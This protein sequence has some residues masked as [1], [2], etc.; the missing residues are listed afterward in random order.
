MEGAVLDGDG[1]RFRREWLN[2]RKRRTSRLAGGRSAE[3]WSSASGGGRRG[4]MPSD[5]DPTPLIQAA[6]T[7]GSLPCPG[8]EECELLRSNVSLVLRGYDLS[9]A[10]HDVGFRQAF[11]QCPKHIARDRKTSIHTARSQIY[12]VH[13]IVRVSDH[14]EFAARIWARACLLAAGDGSRGSG[15]NP[16]SNPPGA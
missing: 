5:R 9:E 16:S 13:K 4:S 7:G 3:G 8:A 6:C 15:Q 12:Q 10:E 14:A 1:D 2:V 11:G